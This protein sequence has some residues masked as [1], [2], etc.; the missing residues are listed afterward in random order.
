MFHN[1]GYSAGGGR[2]IA[3]WVWPRQKWKTLSEKQKTKSK[4][5]RTIAQ[6]VEFL[7]S[8]WETWTQ[9]SVPPRGKKGGG[10]T[11]PPGT[12]TCWP[13]Q[14]LTSSTHTEVSLSGNAT[15]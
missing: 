12:H 2:S 10:R 3:V 9:S 8:N 6:A 4:K 1:Y 14:L 7:L 13:H 5:T 15:N 11:Y